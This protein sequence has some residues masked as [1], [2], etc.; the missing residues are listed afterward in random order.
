MLTL[1]VFKNGLTLMGVNSFL[2]DTVTGLV[3]ILAIIVDYI[4]RKTSRNA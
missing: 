1:Q 4:K 3:I 2:Q